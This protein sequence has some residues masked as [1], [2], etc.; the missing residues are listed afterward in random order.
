MENG[1]QDFSEILP[2]RDIVFKLMLGNPQHTRALIHLLNCMRVSE[3]PIAGVDILNSEITPENVV[4]KGFRLDIKAQ[5][6][7]GE[8]MLIEMQCCEDPAMVARVL[9]YWS[10]SFSSQL[11]VG[12]YYDELK[13]TVSITISNFRVFKRD[14]RFWRKFYMTDSETHEKMTDL[15]EMA[16]LELPKVHKVDENDP[17]T[18]WAEFLSR[19]YCFGRFQNCF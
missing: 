19:P 16:F 4:L 8:I 6:D 5:T 10:D 14:E 2:T 12:E 9:Q 13:R 17:L 7:K 3:D 11:K 18:Y 15:F 1:E